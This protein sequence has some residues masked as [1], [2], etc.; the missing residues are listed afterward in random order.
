MVFSCLN[1]HLRLAYWVW[2]EQTTGFVSSVAWPRLGLFWAWWSLCGS[3]VLC[4]GLGLASLGWLSL[5]SFAP[6]H[7]SLRYFDFMLPT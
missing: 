2:D 1:T 4:S 3:P 6:P 5:W 7:K